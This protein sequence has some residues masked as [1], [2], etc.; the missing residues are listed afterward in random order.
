MFRPVSSMKRGLGCWIRH[1]ILNWGARPLFRLSV[2]E[3]LRIR[4][5][6]GLG[7]VTAALVTSGATVVLLGVMY[8]VR[9][10]VHPPKKK[11]DVSLVHDGECRS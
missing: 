4:L 10:N 11:K 1:E 2:A 8:E 6:P 5:S 3:Q 9:R 7:I